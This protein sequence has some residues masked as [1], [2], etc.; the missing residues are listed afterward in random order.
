M[1]P[2]DERIVNRAATIDELLSAAGPASP[3]Q[4][5]ATDLAERRYEAWCRAAAGSDTALFK[6]RLDRD[7]LSRQ[8]VLA[9]LAAVYTGSPAWIEDASWVAAALERPE[10]GTVEPGST[11]PFE[12]LLTP[13]IDAAAARLWDGLTPAARDNLSESS[14]GDLRDALMSDLS[15]LS[16]PAI[17]DLFAEA[18]GRGTGYLEFVA[19]M[20]TAGFRRLFEAKPVLLRLMSSLTR[21]WIDSSHEFVTRLA[22]DIEAIRRELLGTDSVSRVAA[23]EGRLSDRHNFG[24]SVR[25][26]EF[27]TG[28]RVVYKPKDLSVDAVWAALV[29]RLNASTPPIDLRAVQVLAR[30]GYGWTEFIE[31]TKCT[32]AQ[33]FALFFFRAGAW[34]ALFHVFVAVDM[35]QENILAAGSHPVPIDLE[36]ILQAADARVYGD[37]TNDT[38]QAYAAAMETVVNSVLTI[39]LLPA[40]GRH[41][42]SKVFVI[43]GVNSNSSSRVT[44]RWTDVN[45]DSMSPVKVTDTVATVSNL[46]YFDGQ[47]GSLGDHI[48]DL[49]SGFAEYARFLRQKTVTALFGDFTGLQIRT[50][51]RPTRFYGFLLNRLRDRHM[52]DDGAVWSAQADFV[53]RLA[54]WEID[55]DPMW[56]LL[57]EERAALVDLNV[58]HFTTD[59]GPGIHRATGRLG[60][61]DDREIEWQLEVIRQNTDLL[62]HRPPQPL[63]VRTAGTASV[64]AVFT[65]EAGA[66]AAALASHAVR[67]GRSAA[68]IGLDWLGDSEISQLVV[69]GPDL[70]N[71]SCGIGVFLAAYGAVTGDAEAK[72]LARSAVAGL[73]RQMRGRNPA[74][75]A[76]SL[77]I[78]GGLGLGS[79]VYALAVIAALVDDEAVLDDAHAAAALITEE[80]IADDHHLD[81][82]S[83]SAG[84]ILGLLRLYRQSGRE[85]ALELA[86]KC[87]RRLTGHQRA[88]QP[89]ARTWTSPVFGHPL[90]GM[91]HGAAGFAYSLASLSSATGTQEFAHEATECIAFENSTFDTAH[92]GWADL[93]GIADSAWP[94]KWCYGSAGIGLAR[95]AMTK[96]AGEPLELRAHDIGRALDGVAD[97]W[98]ATTDTL[99]C[100]TLGS[101]E[102]LTEAGDVL[103]RG[104]LR[105]LAIERLQTVVET[106]RATGDYRWSGGTSRFNLGLFR[107]IA[108]VGY[109]LLRAVN[110]S[111]PN[112]LVWE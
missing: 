1:E 111:L 87:G 16:A 20:K 46:P 52:M 76:R 101:I 107:G 47:R 86:E 97:A 60:E 4:L 63:M 80:V 92:R 9:R 61:L 90:N 78:G 73:R 79:I 39:G 49:M 91:S 93:R 28:E 104:E 11:V 38:G 85:D 55:S 8:D 99:C 6:R 24:R 109:T 50:V 29:G 43:G 35:H 66:I 72:E 75:I 18:R 77:G 23:I 103:D 54:D 45:T 31:H 32:C 51:I 14:V 57:R 69:L 67:R 48:D 25:I 88:G 62:R 98:P 42:T 33:D 102:F 112:V 71:G 26:L 58:P 2:G 96:H 94:C 41:S 13:V 36:M 108:G 40:Y 65:A 44:V 19:D 10:K 106:R 64:E 30:E 81:V 34:L 95:I 68:W 22:A 53:A 37:L 110:P 89:G 17:Y 70:Y 15:E 12:H 84:A 105:E 59:T 5:R 21:Q 82:L 3:E 56:P 27:E 100:G 74:R 83:G 7:G